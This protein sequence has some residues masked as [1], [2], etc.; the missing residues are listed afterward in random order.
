LAGGS[1]VLCDRQV[2]TRG[3]VGG[4]E[5]VANCYGRTPE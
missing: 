2:A 4:G 3:G 1:V 5:V